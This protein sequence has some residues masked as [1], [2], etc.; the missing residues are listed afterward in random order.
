MEDCGHQVQSSVGL[1]SVQVLPVV[2]YSSALPSASFS[3]IITILV[4]CRDIFSI[5]FPLHNS[6]TAW[7]YSGDRRH[8]DMYGRYGT[9]HTK[10]RYPWCRRPPHAV[11]SLPSRTHLPLSLPLLFLGCLVNRFAVGTQHPLLPGRPRAVHY[12]RA[13][14]TRVL[15]EVSGCGMLRIKIPN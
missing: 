2:A 8:A 12:A 9:Y 4:E 13:V 15:E 1:L 14:A 6:C 5:F 7:T 3:N 10:Y 11:S